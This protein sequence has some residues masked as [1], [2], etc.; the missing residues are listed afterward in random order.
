MI[1]LVSFPIIFHDRWSRLL[2]RV[3]ATTPD[4][5]NRITIGVVSILISAAA[6]FLGSGGLVKIAQLPTEIQVKA[7]NLPSG[8]TANFGNGKS[9]NI[10]VAAPRDIWNELKAENFSAAIDVAKRSEGTYDIDIVVTSQIEKAK[11]VRVSPEKAVVTVEPVIKKTVP[12]SLKISGSAG[13]DLVAG[14]AKIDPE[15]VEIA[16]A[17]A[18]VNEISQVYG[19]I[20]LNGESQEITLDQL[21]LFA[22]GSDGERLTTIEFTPSTIKVVLPLVKAG[23]TKTLSIKPQFTGSPALGYWVD[24]VSIN[25][26]TATV[27]G[28]AG[29]LTDLKSLQTEAISLDGLNQTTTKAVKLSLPS[30]VTLLDEENLFSVKITISKTDSIK[31]LNPEIIYDGVAAALKV[32]SINPISLSLV[33]GG[34]VDLLK[35]ASGGNVKLRLNLAAYKSAGT[36]SVTIANSD[37]VLPSGVSIISFLPSAI[38]VTLENR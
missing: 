34:P 25:P 30:G 5:L 12:V 11:V 18:L 22:Q 15:K 32:A 21:E 6:V 26:P 36:Y 7:V 1:L 3:P 31:S 10:I 37:L 2:N 24:S 4:Y 28:S 35:N 8:M 19:E 20:V 27:Q 29:V 16:G 38:D 23:N 13:N 9:V 33:I 14:E 17:K